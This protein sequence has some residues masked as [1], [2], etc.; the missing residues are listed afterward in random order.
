M[1]LLIILDNGHGGLI[2]N[3]YQTKGKQKKWADGTHIYEGEFNRAIVRGIAEELVKLDIDFMILVPGEDDLGLLN[4]AKLANAQRKRSLLISVHANAGGG[5]GVEIFTSPGETKSDK[6]A[7]VFG[8]EYQKEFPTH[9]LRTDY[10]SDG[11][12]DKEARFTIL[13]KTAMPAILTENFFMDNYCECKGI[14]MTEKGRERI[15]RYHVEAIKRV[16]KLNLI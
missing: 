5:K 16:I 9:H 1:G 14:L 2:N 7:T 13:T 12:L 15:I 10:A 8:E 4:R 6:V 3:I 11:D